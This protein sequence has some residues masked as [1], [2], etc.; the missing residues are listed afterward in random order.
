MDTKDLIAKINAKSDTINSKAKDL[1][2]VLVEAGI[3]ELEAA[4][5]KLMVRELKGNNGSS[6][7][8]LMMVVDGEY[9]FM[10][11][12]L[13]CN[14]SAIR[15]ERMFFHDFQC[16]V[17]RPSRNDLVKFATALPELVK[18]LEEMAS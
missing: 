8:F 18:K 5:V 3:G 12:A 14:V 4:G 6:M 11:V 13:E 15:E 9:D 1:L 7:D 16:I 10:E 17:N 2:S